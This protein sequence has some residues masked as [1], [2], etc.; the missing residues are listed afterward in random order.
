[1]LKISTF[2]EIEPEFIERVHAVVWCNGATVDTHGRP[3]TRV[4]HPIWEG[5]TG[6]VT[7]RRSSPKVKH[8]AAN[9]FL[10]LAYIADPFKPIYVECRAVWD[11]DLATRQRIWDLLRRTPP[12]LGFDPALTWG[13]IEDPE[14]GLLRLTPWRI[15]LNDYSPPPQTKVWRD[16][17]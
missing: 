15:E 2:A 8:L 12:P 16:A 7:T 17:Q 1:M 4:L 3:R 6:W 14:N 10:S 13:D 5:A 9:P 11:G